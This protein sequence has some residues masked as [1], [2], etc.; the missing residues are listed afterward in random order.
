[1]CMLLEE[2]KKVIEYVNVT[3]GRA[4]LIY[5]MCTLHEEVQI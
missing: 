1:M 5:V 3:W 2:G 4:K